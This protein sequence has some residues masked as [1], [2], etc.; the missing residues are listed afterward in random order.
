MNNIK[1][2]LKVGDVLLFKRTKSWSPVPKLIR[3]IEGNR[4]VHV[5]VVVKEGPD[6][7][8]AE[9]DAGFRMRVGSW[10]LVTKKEIPDVARLSSDYYISKY[11][12]IKYALSVIGM[13]YGY[14]KIIDSMIN[15]FLG[16]LFSV[17]GK[18]HV[19]KTYVGNPNHEICSTLVSKILSQITSLNYNKFSEPDDY[20]KPPFIVIYKN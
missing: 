14:S 2:N 8:I 4:Y 9:I 13:S 5:A 7:L 16:F 19:Y 12:I 3:L 6:P 17:F 1:E 20:C 18:R 15:H 10:E 11:S